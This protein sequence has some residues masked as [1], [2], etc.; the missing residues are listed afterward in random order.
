MIYHL[1]DASPYTTKFIAFL[2]GHPE[3][4]A[5]AEHS[6]VIRSPE[7]SAFGAAAGAESS[8][9]TSSGTSPGTSSGTTLVY[10]GKR[11]F[12]ATLGRVGAG[13]KVVI[14]GLFNPWLV[15]YLSL[16]PKLLRQCVWCIWGADLYLYRLK[17]RTVKEHLTERL[18]GRV[19]R[20][21]GAI[22]CFVRGDYELARQVYRTEAPYIHSFYPNP[23]DFGLLDEAQPSPGDGARTLMVGNSGDPTNRHAEILDLLA[24]HRGADIRIVAP[25]SYGDKDNALAVTRYAQ[26]RFGAKFLA[27]SEF[28]PAADYVGLLAGVDVAIMNHDR[29][30]ALGNVLAILALGKKVYLRS[31]TTPY[32]FFNEVG[33]KV[34]DTLEL[35][36]QPLDE[37]LAFDGETAAR[38]AARVRELLAEARAVAAWQEVLA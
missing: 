31:D 8:P 37:I 3:S 32:S 10:S 11:G 18:R 23:V 6:F 2:R 21:L 29:Q 7:G 4:F 35:P 27:L 30:Q 17:R 20:R 5:F 15:V 28:M 34:F 16:H 38:N 13:D 22:A 1:F 33:I 36:R 9:G 19:I 24:P 26:E 25:L 12:W 14:H